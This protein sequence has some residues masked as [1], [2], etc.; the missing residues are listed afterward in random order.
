MASM[1]KTFSSII[2]F[3][4]ENLSPKKKNLITSSPISSS[5]SDQHQIDYTVPKSPSITLLDEESLQSSI[6]SSSHQNSSV[7]STPKSTSLKS[8]VPSVSTAS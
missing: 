8:R 7:F 5:S 6:G 2:S 3:K 4:K 1:W